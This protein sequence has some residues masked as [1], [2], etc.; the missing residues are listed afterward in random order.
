MKYLNKCKLTFIL[1]TT[2]IILIWIII[3]IIITII[4]GEVLFF[5]NAYL[6][7]FIIIWIIF[8]FI[9]FTF[10]A[11]TL[12]YFIWIRLLSYTFTNVLF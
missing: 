8:T 5:Y 10:V 11:I 7:L 6:Y 9:L 2:T 12:F 1:G 3:W 4:F